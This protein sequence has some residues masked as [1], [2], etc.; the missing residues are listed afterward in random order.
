M[1][2]ECGFL[3]PQ[4]PQEINDY[5]DAVSFLIHHPE[6]RAAMARA[7]RERILRDFGREQTLKR[8]LSILHHADSLALTHPRQ[9]VTPGLAHELATLAVEY[10]R[11]NGLADSLW[12][13]W[14]QTASGM[15]AP[16]HLL[17][18][19]NLGRLLA[20]LA[21]TRFGATLIRNPLIRGAGKWLVQRLEARQRRKA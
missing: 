19:G 20:L 9:P 7:G 15:N 14:M 13:Q 4:G 18:P 1:T 12:S 8:L 5:A 21:G 16:S 10:A 2:S 3:V 11:L 17:P 6:R